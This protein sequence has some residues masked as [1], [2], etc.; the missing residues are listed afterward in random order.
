MRKIYYITLAL[1]LMIASIS[2]CSAR[3]YRVAELPNGKSFDCQNCHV[4][5]LG[6]GP[7]NSFGK[8]VEQSYLDDNGDVIWNAEL[9]ALDS[10]G[11]GF[12]NGTELQDPTGIWKKGNAEPG[13]SASVSNPGDKASTPPTSVYDQSI[14]NFS[15][16]PNPMRYSSKISFYLTNQSYL[17]ISVFNMNGSVVRNIFSGQQNDGDYNFLWDGRD[18]VNSIL[19]SGTYFICMSI[20]YSAFN[21]LE[22]I[23]IS[24]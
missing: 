12:S 1:S 23:I 16:S 5:K 14:F 2:I 18:N 8:I 3:D 11:D 9:A 21:V 15:I 22:K 20:N 24:K 13:L 17:R 10:D 4:D 6:K 19:P 7:R